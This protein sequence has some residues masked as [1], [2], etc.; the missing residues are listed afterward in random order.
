MDREVKD[1]ERGAR[2]ARRGERLGAE[3]GGG[4]LV[5]FVLRRVKGGIG[6]FDKD[7][8]G[9]RVVVLPCLTGAGAGTCNV[10]EIELDFCSS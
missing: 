4:S 3:E 9:F 1:A 7:F 2:A 8:D 5:L 6:I 10:F